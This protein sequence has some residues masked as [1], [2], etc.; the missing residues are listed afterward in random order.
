MKKQPE[1]TVNETL[2]FLKQNSNLIDVSDLRE[3]TERLT[4]TLIGNALDI[5]PGETTYFGRYLF[6]LL[7]SV[8]YNVARFNEWLDKN[9]AGDV[10]TF[11]LYAANTSL[12]YSYYLNVDGKNY[13]ISQIQYSAP[14]LFYFLRG[15][16]LGK[17]DEDF[18]IANEIADEF[19]KAGNN[20]KFVLIGNQTIDVK[21]YN[22]G[23]LDIKGLTSEQ[24]TKVKNL[25][26]NKKRSFLNPSWDDKWGYNQ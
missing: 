21:A 9:F 4:K 20:L 5:Y 12:F 26:A 18:E 15:I 19:K 17:F 2:D 11:K 25:I 1:R 7:Q 23:R 8:E 22:N 16:I 13:S 3:P 10:E 14:N 6:D 24:E